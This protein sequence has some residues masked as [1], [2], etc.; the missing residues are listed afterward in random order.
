MIAQAM[1]FVIPLVEQLDRGTDQ[2]VHQETAENP[3]PPGGCATE[4]S[5]VANEN[6]QT[7]KHQH[8]STAHRFIYLVYFLLF[9]I[10]L[11][12]I[13]DLFT[14]LFSWLTAEDR[15]HTDK[16]KFKKKKKEMGI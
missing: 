16:K 9:F 11:F 1:S 14:Y 3:P 2:G 5:K 7:H 8:I 6:K 13:I 4:Q 10:Y 12:F 15:S